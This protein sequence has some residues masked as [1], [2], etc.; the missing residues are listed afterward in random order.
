MIAK[1][2]VMHGARLVLKCGIIR[3]TRRGLR[4]TGGKP[5]RE[6]HFITL[7]GGATAAWPLA[8]RAQQGAM[9]RVGVL[10]AFDEHDARAKGWL[11]QFFI[12]KGF[13]SWA[14]LRA[15]TCR[16]RFAGLAT[17]LIQGRNVR[18]RNWLRYDRA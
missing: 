4:G 9:K 18:E 6:R 5:M 8:A 14:G 1:L 13:C 7:V 2:A 10:M 17:T 11:S 16:W 12:L 3:H 15:A